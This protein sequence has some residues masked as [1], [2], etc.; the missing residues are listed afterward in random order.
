MLSLKERLKAKFN[1]SVAEL[2]D[3]DLWQRCLLGMAI[4]ANDRV[5]ANSVLSKATD[6]VNSTPDAIVTDTKLE[7]F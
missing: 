5:Y 2:D 3:N 1:L 7:W 6:L 4:I